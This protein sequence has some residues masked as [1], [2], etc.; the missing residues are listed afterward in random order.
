MLIFYF[1]LLKLHLINLKKGKGLYWMETGVP[2]GKPS[3]PKMFIL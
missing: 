3:D 1:Y 2:G